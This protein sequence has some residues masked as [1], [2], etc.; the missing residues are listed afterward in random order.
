MNPVSVQGVAASGTLADGRVDAIRRM[1][2]ERGREA[3]A[4]ELQVALFTQLLEAMRKTLPEN[5]LLPRSPARDV[6]DGMFDRE[7]ANALAS[8]DPLG[9]VEHLGRAAAGAE[10]DSAGLD[11]AQRLPA[12][13]GGVA[14]QA[15]STIGSTGRDTGAQAHDGLH[16]AGEV[17][18]PAQAA[19]TAH[20]MKRATAP[21]SIQEPTTNGR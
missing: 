20:A 3:A 8:S 14:G 6:Y 13:A 9:L 19:L 17:L 11:R 15:R 5:S 21:G 4:R 18:A 1:G 12:D 2:P 10:D 16:G 7:L